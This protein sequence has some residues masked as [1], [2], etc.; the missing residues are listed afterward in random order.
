MKTVQYST[1]RYAACTVNVCGLKKVRLHKKT[2]S[3]RA[4]LLQIMKNRIV[5]GLE[6]IKCIG[7]IEKQERIPKLL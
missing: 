7:N 1:L 2:R 4:F 5:G 6:V 3:H